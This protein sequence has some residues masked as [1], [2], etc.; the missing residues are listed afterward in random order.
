MPYGWIFAYIIGN[1]CMS[2]VAMSLRWANSGPWA[3]CFFFLLRQSALC[4]NGHRIQNQLL[5]QAPP[6][7]YEKFPVWK[8]CHFGRL[9]RKRSRQKDHCIALPQSA[10]WKRFSYA[11]FQNDFTDLFLLCPYTKI[12]KMVLLW[13]IEWLPELKIERTFKGHLL[14]GQ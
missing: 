10:T 4:R 13:W 1:I 12:A 3:S 2:A 5:K 11:W 7:F 6:A 9:F 14:Q 8:L